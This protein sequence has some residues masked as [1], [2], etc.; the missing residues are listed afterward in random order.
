MI[1]VSQEKGNMNPSEG[2]LLEQEQLSQ[3]G[4]VMHFSSCAISPHRIVLRSSFQ[5][6]VIDVN[7]QVIR[8]CRGVPC[9]KTNQQTIQLE[10]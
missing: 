2:E 9:K 5:T 3:R 8:V 4:E 7:N 6:L 1:L 10:K